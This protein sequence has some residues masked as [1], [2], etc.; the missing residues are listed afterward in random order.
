MDLKVSIL[1]KGQLFGERDWVINV[2]DNKNIFYTT[3]VRWASVKGELYVIRKED[4]LNKI[5]HKEDSW[6]TFLEIAYT[7]ENTIQK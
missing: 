1:T 7:R 3:S 5:K 4:F 2:G 6:N